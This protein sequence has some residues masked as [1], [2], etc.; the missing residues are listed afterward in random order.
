MMLKPT[1][2]KQL[3]SCLIP[4]WGSGPAL[5]LVCSLKSDSSEG[6][7]WRT[8]SECGHP[9]GLGLISHA[10]KPGAAAGERQG[11]NLDLLKRGSQDWARGR[12]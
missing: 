2:S 3:W 5:G 11:S 7:K 8:V 12:L 1:G 9:L 6:A 4:G 10:S